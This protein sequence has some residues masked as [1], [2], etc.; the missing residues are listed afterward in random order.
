[1]K[2]YA[3]IFARGGSKGLPGKNIK[4]LLGVPLIAYSIKVAQ[5][6]K[7]ID[8]IFVSTDDDDIALVASE[9]GAEV[10]NRP[11]SLA[12]D[13]SAEWDAWRHAVIYVNDK[14]GQFDIFLSLPA[15]APLRNREDVI[16]CLNIIKDKNTDMVITVSES[17][18]NPHFNMV[19]LNDTGIVE[20][21]NKT[22]IKIERRQDVP[23]AFNITTVAYATRPS[24]IMKN[25]GLFDGVVRSVEI[26]PERAIDIDT[27]TDFVVA[28]CLMGTYTEPKHEKN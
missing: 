11:N 5:S 23:A 8:K 27:Y 13:T 7:E 14:Y 3:F 6:I 28:Q 12:Q 9:F 2:I 25:E 15:T 18:N 1:M 19:K 26:P 17:H 22:N 16:S 10:I 20:L 24:F 4:M 21:F